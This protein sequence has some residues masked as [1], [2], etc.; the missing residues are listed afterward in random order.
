MGL[1]IEILIKA[2]NEELEKQKNEKKQVPS[3]PASTTTR[4]KPQPSQIEIL[5]RALDEE[6]EKLKNEKTRIPHQRETTTKPWIYKGLP[7]QNLPACLKNA[8]ADLLLMFGQ[9][10]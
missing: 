1:A 8:S 6:L 9:V 7:M 10:N 5:I 2:L 4:H 3:Q